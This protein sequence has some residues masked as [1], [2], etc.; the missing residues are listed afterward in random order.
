MPQQ[1]QSRL[2]TPVMESVLS[3]QQNFNDVTDTSATIKARKV[4]FII[5]TQ[6]SFIR[7]V[8]DG[9]SSLHSQDLHRCSDFLLSIS[10]SVQR[11]SAQFGVD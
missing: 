10:L 9:S 3:R 5:I 11:Q 8:T 6:L 7:Y 2:G 1:R 4:K